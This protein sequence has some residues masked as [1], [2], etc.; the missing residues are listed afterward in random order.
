MAKERRHHLHDELVRAEGE[1][2]GLR[3]AIGARVVKDEV[4]ARLNSE[5]LTTEEAK[6]FAEKFPRWRVMSGIR[7]GEPIKFYERTLDDVKP[8]R[9]EDPELQARLTGPDLSSILSGQDARAA[10]LDDMDMELADIGTS[11]ILNGH[12]L[13]IEA[14]AK[15][16]GTAIT[17]MDITRLFEAELYLANSGITEPRPLPPSAA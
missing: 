5:P 10:G 15:D 1:N 6:V 2:R 13:K 17:L 12:Y 8:A 11:K 3:F 9:L 7:N 16:A 4:Q 14:P